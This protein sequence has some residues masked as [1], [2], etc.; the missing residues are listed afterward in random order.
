[1]NQYKLV[2]IDL[3]FYAQ[4]HLRL[5]NEQ[6]LR[7]AGRG[8]VGLYDEKENWYI[9]IRSNLGKKKPSNACFPTPFQ[10]SNPHFKNPG[11]DF[12]KAIYVPKE[13]TITI[14]NTMPTDQ[15]NYISDNEDKIRK[16]FEEYVLFVDSANKK[17]ASY[18]FS[19]IPLFPEGIEKI[20]ALKQTEVK[21]IDSEK[22]IDLRQALKNQNPFEVKK[23]LKLDLV[24]YGKDK[25]KLKD[26][27][28]I[29]ARMPYLSVENLQL[30]VAQKADIRKFERLTDWQMENPDE[31]NHPVIYQ[32]LDTQYVTKLDEKGQPIIDDEGK[33][34]RYK[35]TELIDI[36]EVESSKKTN[37]EWT[38]N[39]Y[40]EVFKKLKNLTVYEIK[41][42]KINQKYQVD[43]NKK[44]I[45]IQEHLGYE[46]TMLTIIH[47]ITHQN[48]KDKNQ[49]FLADVHEYVLARR[50]ELPEAEVT[51]ESLE[52]KKLS[53][54]EI[55]NVLKFIS[56]EGKTFIQNAERQMFH[57]SLETKFE[58]KFEER[59]AK[60]K[61]DKNKQ[62]HKNTQ[63]MSKQNSPKGKRP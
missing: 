7:K 50:L 59:V 55:Y 38:N 49:L 21:D 35:T 40:V 17:S 61:A 26:Y 16:A 13:Y 2:T 46:A 20:K 1:M 28:K 25:N 23:A 37:K 53:E 36:V 34:V 41:I 47:A 30:L 10:T 60:A 54:T 48:A 27:L 9:P 8:Y 57:P 19:T 6:L 11:L 63:Q 15:A 4:L 18:R 42:D 39:D 33:A 3:A 22:E 56:K 12:Q 32:L 51:F 14:Q 43:D 5:G 24:S 58:S 29:F 44:Q 52:E 62:T 31:K 45:V